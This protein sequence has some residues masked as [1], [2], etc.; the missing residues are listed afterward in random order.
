MSNNIKNLPLRKGFQ[1]PQLAFYLKQL[2][3][4]NRKTNLNLELFASIFSPRA[5]VEL[6]S[7]NLF[8]RAGAGAF[9]HHFF[10]SELELEPQGSGGQIG[11]GSKSELIVHICKFCIFNYKFGSIIVNQWIIPNINYVI[12]KEEWGV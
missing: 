5:G 3:K 10:C 9:K 7:S 8:W 6:F 12:A 1:N 2:D 11:A 4:L